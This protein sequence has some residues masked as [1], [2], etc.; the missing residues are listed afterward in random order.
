MPSNKGQTPLALLDGMIDGLC[1]DVPDGVLNEVLIEEPTLTRLLGTTKCHLG[2]CVSEL[3]G[4]S[5]VP[6]NV[7]GMIRIHLGPNGVHAL[8]LARAGLEALYDA[9]GPKIYEFDAVTQLSAYRR[10]AS[11]PLQDFVK[12]A[13]YWTAYPMARMLNGGK[14]A[15]T[16]ESL[17]P[18]PPCPPA[19]F[20]PT[21]PTLT[22]VPVTE[23]NTLGEVVP[24]MENVRGTLVPKMTTVP[25]LGFGPSLLYS[26]AL[27]RCLKNRLTSFCRR[28]LSLALTLLQG[29]KRG[30]EQVPASFIHE[31]M[32]KHRAALT[33]IPRY[34]WFFESE[35]EPLFQRFYQSMH[36]V[37]P[38]LY[39]ASTSASFEAPRSA[40]G[41]REFLRKELAGV[42]LEYPILSESLLEQYEYRPGEVRE[43]R[44]QTPPTFTE[45][46]ERIVHRGVM[47]DPKA[48]YDPGLSAHTTAVREKYANALDHLGPIQLEPEPDLESLLTEEELSLWKRS[49]PARSPASGPKPPLESNVMVSGVLEPLKVRLITKGESWKYWFSRFYQKHL[50]HDLQRHPQ[51]IATGRPI[52]ICDFHD[53]VAREKKLGLHFPLWVSGDYSAATDNVKIGYTKMAFEASLRASH[54]SEDLASLLRSV[55]YE[56][57]I[58]YPKKEG[59]DP[60]RQSN[61]QLM[62]STLSFPILC[63]INLVAYWSALE[64]YLG[65]QVALDDLPVL[66]NGD[67]IL[68]RTDRAFYAIWME[69]AL[70]MGFELSLGKNYVHDRFFTINSEGFMWTGETA[71]RTAEI[72]P[73]PF[74]NIG[75]LMGQAKVTARLS[76]KLRPIWDFYNEVIDGAHS[77]VRA[78]HRFLHY[79]REVIEKLTNRGEYN[80]FISQTFGGLGFKLDPEVK[81]AGGPGGAPVHF[82]PFQRRFGGYLKSLAYNRYEGEFERFPLWRGLVSPTKVKGAVRHVFHQGSFVSKD[83]MCPRQEF[84]SLASDPS[85]TLKMPLAITRVN[86]DEAGLQVRRPKKKT[87]AAF[88]AVK[89][90]ATRPSNLL[91]DF[92]VVV[93]VHEHAE[94]AVPTS[95]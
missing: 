69:A 20:C 38:A 3:L 1:R 55:L 70:E 39:E 41:A 94:P 92:H 61:G 50:W 22:S 43:I 46:R 10:M 53:L 62:G 32:L 49:R 12:N 79:H 64:R 27:K 40:G 42:S 75:L 84:E 4:A 90:T 14:D 28:N 63:A 13:K 45:I 51:F 80:L 87:L 19:S 66:L 89:P 26:G 30:C 5:L 60:V 18:L 65:R 36:P 72:T 82:T 95:N 15:S 31:T 8:K 16:S 58:N 54:T 47:Q 24:V 59:I 9:L 76:M 86:P 73:V 6:T 25:S 37:K 91:R 23:R 48:W 2:G 81:A 71:T 56:Q 74:L 88:R 85:E 17:T 77:K 7:S 67:D 33:K 21:K 83:R 57:T 78:H 35:F 29:V 93:E 11:W 68:F 34:S 44:G 52:N